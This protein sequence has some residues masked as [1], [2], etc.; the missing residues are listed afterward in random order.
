MLTCHRSFLPGRMLR[1]IAA[2]QSLKWKW[3]GFPSSHRCSEKYEGEELKC[4][5]GT[6]WVFSQIATS[7]LEPK[8]FLHLFLC[9]GGG[10]QGKMECFL[11]PSLCQSKICRNREILN[12]ISPELQR[13]AVGIQIS[14][15]ECHLCKSSTFSYLSRSFRTASV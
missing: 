13:I 14:C 9:P 5:A 8:S 11:P 2:K 4:L 1:G 10:G 6:H 15:P 3:G 12:Q 7:W